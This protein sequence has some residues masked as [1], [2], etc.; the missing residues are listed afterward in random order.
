MQRRCADANMRVLFD[1]NVPD[2][3]RNHLPSH[4]VHLSSELGWR[5]LKNG[6]LLDTA[7]REGFDVMLTADQNLRYQQNLS[8]REIA[9]VVIGSNLWPFVRRHL[10]E[11]ASAIDSATP[12]HLAFIEVPLPPRPKRGLTRS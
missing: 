2:P 1:V 8:G 9:L 4:E 11:I 10:S 5:L 7:E 6:L 3:L 12:G